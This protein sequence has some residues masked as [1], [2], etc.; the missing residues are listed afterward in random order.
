MPDMRWLP[1]PDVGTQ[2]AVGFDGSDVSDWTVLGAETRDG[3]SFT[4]RYGP[5]RL[6]TIWKP[7][8]WDGRV[9]RDQVRIAVDELFERFQVAR[10]YADPWRWETD[11]EDWA[12]VYGERV[13][14]WPTNKVVPMHAA[15]ERFRTDLAEKRIR[16]DGCPLTATAMANAKELPKTSDRYILGKPSLTQKIDPT[17]GRVLAHEAAADARAAGWPDNEPAGISHAMYGFN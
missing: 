17:M 5:N 11:I 1:E 13:L 6:P 12:L 10:L 9:P 2:I 7:E 3:F 16:H 8:E 4:P 15:L 14:P